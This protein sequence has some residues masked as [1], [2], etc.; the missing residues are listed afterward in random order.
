MRTLK[1]GQE[2]K[3]YLEFKRNSENKI[4]IEAVDG[5]GHKSHFTI[6][7]EELEIL[8]RYM[9]GEDDEQSE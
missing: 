6:A 1:L 2:D 8:Y 7:D 9:I 4:Y 5:E 3:N